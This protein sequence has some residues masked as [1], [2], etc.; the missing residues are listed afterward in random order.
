MVATASK[1]YC[2]TGVLVASVCMVYYIPRVVDLTGGT[3]V[4]M[5]WVLVATASTVYFIPGVF[6]TT[7]RTVYCIPRVLV[8]TA[9]TVYWVT[10]GT[11]HSG[12][13]VLVSATGC[14]QY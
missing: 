10:Y 11:V 6:I 1:R 12:T 3:V 8:T 13:W 14:T 4:C 5:P 7:P 2:I 9:V